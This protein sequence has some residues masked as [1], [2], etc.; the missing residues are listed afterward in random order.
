MIKISKDY[1]KVPRWLNVSR[2]LVPDFVVVDPKVWEITGTEFTRAGDHTAGADNAG[3]KG[4]SI[5]FPRVTK[6]RPDKTWKEATDVPRLE[7]LMQTST[8]LSDWVDKLNA[9][10][11]PNSNKRPAPSSSSDSPGPSPC[12][13][14]SQPNSNHC[15]LDQQLDMSVKA[16][17]PACGFMKFDALF[18]GCGL[19]FTL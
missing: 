11:S 17:A 10:S 7:A 19:T 16:A 18:L 5:R 13:A 6:L 12:K 9:L 3:A 14:G 4:I 15:R 1:S 2:S 8:S